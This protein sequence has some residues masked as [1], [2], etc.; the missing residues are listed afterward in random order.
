MQMEREKKAKRILLAVGERSDA[1]EREKGRKKERVEDEG[2]PWSCA[3][4]MKLS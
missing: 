1:G 4:L 2:Q 3:T